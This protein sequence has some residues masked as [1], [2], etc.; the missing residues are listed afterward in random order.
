[1][2]I[3]HTNNWKNILNALKWKIGVEFS[4]IARVIIGGADGKADRQY[5]ELQPVGTDMVEFSKSFEIR[6]FEIDI[7]YHLTHKNIDKN[8]FDSILKFVSRFEALIHDNI[9]LTLADSSVAYNCRL[10]SS[11]LDVG[12]DDN[13]YVVKWNW[14]CLHRANLT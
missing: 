2:A 8:R 11:E 1:M 10:E 13:D 7:F 14:R 4:P 9:S 12:D 6:E 3:T 5:I